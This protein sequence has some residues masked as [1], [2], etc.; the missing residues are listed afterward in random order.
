MTHGHW[1]ITHFSCSL[2]L[3]MAFMLPMPSVVDILTFI[4]MINT[5]S[6]D[7]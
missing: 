1:V 5:S 7:F 2:E 3:S 4:S 6:E